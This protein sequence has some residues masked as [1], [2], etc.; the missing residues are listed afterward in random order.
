MTI[1]VV[2]LA[3]LVGA[4]LLVWG[5]CLIVH[6]ISNTS[7]NITWRE[8]IEW[9]RSPAFLKGLGMFLASF[10]MFGV[11]FQLAIFFLA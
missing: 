1:A 9:L 3:G 7:W 4:W 2:I 10:L 5:I 11:T 8:A 6:S